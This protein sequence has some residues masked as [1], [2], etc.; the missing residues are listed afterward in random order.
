MHGVAPHMCDQ[1]G[2][3]LLDRGAGGRSPVFLLLAMALGG[4]AYSL[5]KSLDRFD[6]VALIW[7]RFPT[8][9]GRHP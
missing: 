2:R 3:P 9:A 7:P 6:P 1:V 8:T 5:Q 4:P